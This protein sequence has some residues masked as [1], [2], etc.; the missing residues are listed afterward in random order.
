[1]V[2]V[3]EMKDAKFDG[4]PQAISVV[5]VSSEGNVNLKK[6]V[7]DYLGISDRTL[8]LIVGKEILLTT[9]RSDIQAKIRGNRLCLPEEILTK[10][11]L[12]KGSLV[13]MLQRS[14]AVA[15]KKMEIMV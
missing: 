8:Y 12:E 11:E 14:N 4:I 7:G 13:A 15:L 6:N 9:E 3:L 10:L 5:P 2:G 1:M